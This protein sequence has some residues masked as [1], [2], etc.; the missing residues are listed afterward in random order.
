MTNQLDEVKPPVY[1]T[2]NFDKMGGDAVWNSDGVVAMDLANRDLTGTVKPLFS[3][4]DTDMPA[5]IF[6]LNNTY[7]V[8][9]KSSGF[10]A[11]ILSPR[12]LEAIAE[13]INGDG[14]VWEVLELQN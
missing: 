7:Y 13:A 14:D 5:T 6:E 4:T 12:D 2:N 3:Q 9:I 10:L 11:E 1:W 8:Y